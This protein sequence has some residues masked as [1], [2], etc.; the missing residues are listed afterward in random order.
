MTLPESDTT[1]IAMA[2]KLLHEAQR[3]VDQISSGMSK[4]PWD[5]LPEDRKNVQINQAD[6][7]WGKAFPEFYENFC[8]PFRMAGKPYP[9]VSDEDNDLVRYARMLHAI[10]HGV[11]GPRNQEA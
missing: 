9:D 2:A 8:M 7:I 1:P 11:L 5:E 4:V 6:K 3:T 10:V